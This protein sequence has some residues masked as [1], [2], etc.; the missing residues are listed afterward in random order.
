MGIDI[1]SIQVL[2]NEILEVGALA[3]CDT[4]DTDSNGLF[5]CGTDA[6]GAGGGV[7]APNLGGQGVP[8]QGQ[9]TV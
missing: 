8:G 9:Q 5:S 3:N 6:S 1:S 4:I 2:L 7:S